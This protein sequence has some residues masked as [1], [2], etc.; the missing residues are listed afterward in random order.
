MKT[1]RDKPWGVL[2]A[3]LLVAAWAIWLLAFVVWGWSFSELRSAPH[4]GAV[5]YTAVSVMAFVVVAIGL[6]AAIWRPSWGEIGGGLV[7]TGVAAIGC[8]SAVNQLAHWG[9]DV[10]DRLTL[11]P[12]VPLDG[13]GSVPYFVLLVAGVLLLVGG[14]V[15]VVRA[16]RFSAPEEGWKKASVK[17]LR[18]ASWTV[19][20][21][22]LL[23]AVWAVW[24]LAFVVWALTVPEL[25]SADAASSYAVQSA[26]ILLVVVIGLLA[27]VWRP[28][29]GA[30]GGG[31]LVTLLA[32]PQG[33]AAVNGLTHWG[34]ATMG[35][36]GRTTPW[37]PLDSIAGVPY[38]VLLVAA[39]LLV[40]GGVDHVL[41]PTNGYVRVGKLLVAVWAVWLLAFNGWAGNTEELQTENNLYMDLLVLSVM[42]FVVVAIGLVLTRKHGW[43][44]I[45]GGLLVT[46]IAAFFCAS[47]VS[48]LRNWGEIQIGTSSGRSEWSPWVVLDSIWNLPFWALLAAGVLLVVGGIVQ[49]AHPTHHSTPHAGA[50]A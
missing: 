50:A 35:D 33:G 36:Q 19:R 47:S 5:S 15:R 25:K 44:D 13:L 31:L 9:D 41:H 26:L 6:F 46:L 11:R 37:V 42:A 45:A 49:V 48:A 2:V 17:H 34:E 38:W 20:A 22:L 43:G 30:I 14:I 18:A 4:G 8:A 7:V 40:V 27:A 1:L 32:A 21:A 10:P 24:L 16:T 28:G 23:V 29:W 39:V 12:W 3:L